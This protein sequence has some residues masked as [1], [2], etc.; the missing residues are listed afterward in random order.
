[1]MRTQDWGMEVT[2]GAA[3]TAVNAL[4]LL[5]MAL[6]AVGMAAPPCARRIT[7]RIL[8]L[9]LLALLLLLQYSVLIGLPPGICFDLESG[10]AV[11]SWLGASRIE[12]RI[13]MTSHGITRADRSVRVRSGAKLGSCFAHL[14]E[15]LLVKLHLQGF[16]IL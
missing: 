12:T 3:F 5:Y 11:N 1:M 7:W 9:P 10:P 15:M 16:L 6:I 8:S 4:S 14:G 13:G 2:M